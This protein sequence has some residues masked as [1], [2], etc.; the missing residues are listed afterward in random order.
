MRWVQSVSEHRE[1][2][3]VG[4]ISPCMFWCSVDGDGR[5]GEA[6]VVGKLKP[7]ALLVH[8]TCEL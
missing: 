4:D 7:L 8:M 2:A 6:A 5:T 3:L 1:C